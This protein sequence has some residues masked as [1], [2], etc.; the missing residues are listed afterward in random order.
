M[1]E[2]R[3]CL[4]NSQRTTLLFCYMVY[5]QA[6][7]M[8]AIISGH[9]VPVNWSPSGLTISR[10]EVSKEMASLDRISSSKPRAHGRRTALHTLVCTLV[11]TTYRT[12]HR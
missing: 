4:Y 6:T 10:Y 11:L 3:M 5:T 12:R 1:E 2:L 9:A 7:I 8:N